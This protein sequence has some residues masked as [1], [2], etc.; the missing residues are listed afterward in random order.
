MF[1][2]DHGPQGVLLLIALIVALA[3]AVLL[4]A[5][6]VAAVVTAT[7]LPGALLVIPAVLGLVATVGTLIGYFALGFSEEMHVGARLFGLSFVPVLVGA[8]G[9]VSSKP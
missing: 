2:D 5:L 4:L 9:V 7:R 3:C 6:A 1:L 8:V